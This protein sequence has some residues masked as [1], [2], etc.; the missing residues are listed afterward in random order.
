MI[1]SLIDDRM[2]LY[3]LENDIGEKQKLVESMPEKAMQLRDNLQAWFREVNAPPTEPNP[4]YRG[5]AGL[6]SPREE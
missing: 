5:A 4:D 2:E 1:A 3:G 6:D